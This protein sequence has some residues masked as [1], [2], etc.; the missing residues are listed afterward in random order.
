MHI[1]LLNIHHITFNVTA[2][3]K[4]SDLFHCQPPQSM[5]WHARSMNMRI[6]V[7][8]LEMLERSDVSDKIK[9]VNM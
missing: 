3:E 6:R 2:E 9:H 5:G 8:D 1:D 7:F 4:W